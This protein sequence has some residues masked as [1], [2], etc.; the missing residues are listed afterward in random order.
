ML[1][2][3]PWGVY[4]APE[5]RLPGFEQYSHF[6]PTFLYESLWNLFAFGLLLWLSRKFSKRLLDGEIFLLYG[7]LYPLGRFFVEF[8]R[9]DAWKIGGVPTAQWVAIAAILFFGSIL[10]YRRQRGPAKAPAV[11]EERPAQ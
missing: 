5:N 4:I 9:P 8:Q 10:I 3:L 2:N 1:S 11:Q 6:H 7:V